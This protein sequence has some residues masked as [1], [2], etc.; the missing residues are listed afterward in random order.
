[1][2][3]SDDRGFFVELVW[4]DENFFEYFGQVFWLKSYLGVIKVFY[5]YEKQDDFWFF[6]IGYVQVVFYDLCEDLKIKGEIDVYYMGED[7]L[8]L[9]LILKGV[10]YG[11]RVLGEILLMIIYFIIMLYNLD[12]FDEKRILWND[13]MIGFNWNIEFR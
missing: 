12:Q 5:Y 3:Y 9:L 13:E 8:M 11:Y 7:N 2:K 4:D 6:L 1:M 10:V